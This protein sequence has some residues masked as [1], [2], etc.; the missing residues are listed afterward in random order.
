MLTTYAHLPGRRA[1]APSTRVVVKVD[2]VIQGQSV[3]L[4]TKPEPLLN[5]LCEAGALIIDCGVPTGIHLSVVGINISGEGI[6]NIP[7]H[8]TRTIKSHKS[9]APIGSVR[10][11]MSFGAPDPSRPSGQGSYRP[12]EGAPIPNLADARGSETTDIIA[13]KVLHAYAGTMDK[14]FSHASV[15]Y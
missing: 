4:E 6:V 10:L 12:P 2:S 1:I 9:Q 11:V 14:I 15:S 13:L 3:I 7:L 8:P 5:S